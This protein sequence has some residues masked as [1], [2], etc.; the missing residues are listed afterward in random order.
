MRNGL[1]QL[2]ELLV[3]LLHKK[4]IFMTSLHNPV[5]GDFMATSGNIYG[6]FFIFLL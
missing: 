3:K 6:L 1:K 4:T 2:H 5:T